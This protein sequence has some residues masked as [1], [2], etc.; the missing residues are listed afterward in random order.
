MTLGQRI[1][2]YRTDQALSQEALG[3]SLGVSRQAVSRWEADAAVPD[4]DKLIALSKLFAVPVGVLLGV[5]EDGPGR[6]ELTDRELRALEAIAAK[7]TPPPE[8]AAPPPKKRRRAVLLVAAVLAALFVGAQVSQRMDALE[9]QMR[10]LQT[11][12]S[13]VDRNVSARV[14]GIANRVEDLLERQNSVTADQ[15][16]EIASADLAANTVTFRLWATPRVYREGMT[17]QF[18][19]ETG[20]GDPVSVPAEPGEGQRYSATLTCP[21]TDDIALS[22]AFQDGAER[23]NQVLGRET[24]LLQQSKPEVV[25]LLSV[26]GRQLVEEGNVDLTLDQMS[27][28]YWYRGSLTTQEGVLSTDLTQATFRLWRSD[29]PLRSWPIDLPVPGQ[30][31]YPDLG[32]PIPLTGVEEGEI[33][34]FSVLCTDQWGRQFELLVDTIRATWE[35]NSND[36]VLRLGDYT[37]ESYPWET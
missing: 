1:Q 30:P 11:D 32:G 8:P 23:Q 20:L 18:T 21:L 6:E 26:P 36:L 31:A 17:A 16:Y 5:E 35:A 25:A 27:L 33:L 10:N 24:N 37:P 7:L 34:L 3:N 12:V 9:S 28:F 29:R 22:M 13:M 14:D 19:A 15:G 4:V 2:Q